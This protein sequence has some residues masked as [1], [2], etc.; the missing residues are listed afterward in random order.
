MQVVIFTTQT[1]RGGHKAT[2]YDNMAGNI[3]RPL[4]FI[5]SRGEGGT[6]MAVRQLKPK[7]VL[8]KGTPNNA[9][10]IYI[11]KF[12]IIPTSA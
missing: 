1:E 7:F 4:K 11:C 12:E 2:S 9:Y 5:L 10:L 8:H 6:F 3:L